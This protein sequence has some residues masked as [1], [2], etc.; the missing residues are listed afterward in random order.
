MILVIC[1]KEV[2]SANGGK[3]NRY[4]T[5]HGDQWYNVKFTKIAPQL[6]T[7]N[8]GKNEKH[9]IIRGF[10][11]VEPENIDITENKFGKL[12]WV[13]NFNYDGAREAMEEEKKRIEKYREKRESEKRD[14][15]A[16]LEPPP[17]E[18]MAAEKP[19]EPVKADDFPW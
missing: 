15:F 17:E 18:N 13:S 8:I 11:N 16:S 12:I 9:P 7:V 19:L 3:F 6:K 14:F 4:S 2:Q 5:K 1:V 10:I